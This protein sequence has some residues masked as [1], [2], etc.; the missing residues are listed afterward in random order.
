MRV[1]QGMLPVIKITPFGLV[2][3]FIT[4]PVQ[5]FH[6]AFRDIDDPTGQNQLIGLS[7]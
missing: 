1:M 7:T 5:A 4:A 3:A 2:P 6:R